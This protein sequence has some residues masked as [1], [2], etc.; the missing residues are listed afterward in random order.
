MSILK[1]S[2]F[3]FVY[4]ACWT[5]NQ[6][7]TTQRHPTMQSA[8]KKQKTSKTTSVDS[9]PTEEVTNVVIKTEP[10]E[11]DV[12]TKRPTKKL[13]LVEDLSMKDVFLQPIV[14]NTKCNLVPL[15][16]ENNK[17]SYKSPVLVQ[18]NGGGLI[19]L[20]FG[21]EEKDND[22]RTKVQLAFQVDSL[23]DHKHLDRLKN[24]LSELVADNWSNWYPD[25]KVPSREVLLNFCNSFVSERK[26]KKNSEDTWAGVSKASIEPE[27]CVNGKC[28]IVDHDTG[29]TVPYENLPGMKW[30]KIILE[31]KYIYI[32]ATKSYGITKKLRY[33]VCSSEDDDSD[34]VPL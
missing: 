17:A 4:G 24:E 7:L 20:S 28:K 31:L 27:E 30:H 3:N 22:G 33:I 15:S 14:K 5:M 18:L 25:T 23:D 8:Y 16:F 19:P 21:I 6:T 26:Q 13:S 32:Q 11:V 12:V 2:K 34:I 29:D 10:K 1:Y 9:R